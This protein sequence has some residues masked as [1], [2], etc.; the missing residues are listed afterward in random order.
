MTSSSPKVITAFSLFSLDNHE[1]WSRPLD[2]ETIHSYNPGCFI[3]SSACEAAVHEKI[4]N[5]NAFQN[6]PAIINGRVHIVDE[7]AQGSPSQHIV[8][9]YFDLFQ[10]LAYRERQ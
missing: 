3:I 5:N 4:F 10:A 6:L 1:G 8:L 7:D 2:Q 9:A